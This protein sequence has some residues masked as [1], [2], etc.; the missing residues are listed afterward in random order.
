MAVINFK[1][2]NSATDVAVT[3]TILHEA[4]PLT[5]AISRYQTGAYAEANIKNYSHGQFQSVYDY[6]YLSSSSNHIFDVTIGITSDSYC[7]GAAASGSNSG[8]QLK[9]KIN[10]Y[11]QHAQ[12][13]MGYSGSVI[14]K[15][16]SDLSLDLD[17]TN[18]MKE[19]VFIDFSRLLI[20]DEIKKGT[21]S[22]IV[23]NGATW[24]APFATTRT[25]ADSNAGATTGTKNMPG[26]DYGVLVDSLASGSN[27]AGLGVIFYQ[28]GIAVVSASAFGGAGVHGSASNI[29]QYFHTPEGTLK[30]WPA[31]FASASISG[32]CDAVRHRIQNISF[33]NTAE[34]NST[35][36]YCR[37]PHNMFNWSSNPS[38]LTGSEIRVKNGVSTADAI[39]YV[40]TVGLYAADNTLLAVAKLSEPL[41]KDPTNELTLRVRLDY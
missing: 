21:F 28:A 39:S 18:T 4:I 5:G 29:A 3:K 26:G 25:L 33:N 11:S 37:V 41:R 15:F 12:V 30:K 23:G 13:L 24:D 19:C 22:M 1:Q 31:A 38:Y 27:P 32:N 7:S 17:T 20:K 34:I 36:Y 40:T 10:M 16:E 14:R 6:P 35:I 2:L 8:L 9:Q